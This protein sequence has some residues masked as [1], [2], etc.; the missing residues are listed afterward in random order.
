MVF[1]ETWRYIV[2]KLKAFLKRHG[3]C[4]ISDMITTSNISREKGFS[5]IELLT[6][7]SLMAILAA[8]AMPNLLKMM[9]GMRVNTATRQVVSKMLLL[10]M[11]VIS[12]N[13]R[14]Q[15]L[16]TPGG[17]QYQ[18]QQDGNRDGDYTDS[19]DTI[20]ETLNLPSGII[21]GT[22]AIKNTSGEPIDSGSDGVS[23]S[24]ES[25]SFTTTGTVESGSVYLIPREDNVAGGRTDRMR[26]ISIANTGRVKAWRYTGVSPDY[27]TN[28]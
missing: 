21:F 27:W 11:K 28:L 20:V 15:L 10:R 2:L 8:I 26:A 12:E 16:F 6:V 24:A 25:C 4:T 22:N 23:F 17:D 7:V 13:K 18:V 3:A 1:E 9:P 14:Y 5:L 19:T